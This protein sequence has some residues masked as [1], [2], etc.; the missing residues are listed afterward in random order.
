METINADVILPYP[1]RLTSTP[2]TG[3]PGGGDDDDGGTIE[4]PGGVIV[5]VPEAEEEAE[6]AFVETP[7]F[8]DCHSFGAAIG[9]SFS[10]NVVTL[11][12][13]YESRNQDWQ[14]ERL[15][16]DMSY[17]N[18]TQAQRNEIAAFHR[19]VRGQAMAFRVK[20]HSDFEVAQSEGR[21]TESATA[22]VYLM[23]KRY[24]YEVLTYDRDIH[25]PVAGTVKIYDGGVEMVSGF[26]VDYTTGEVTITSGTGP[27]TW[28]GEFDVPS[29]F[30]NDALQWTIVD[31]SGASLLYTSEQL[32]LIEVRL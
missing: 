21:L 9:P 11:K 6:L 15:V 28:S 29:R 18:R 27:F 12:S 22:G 7:R 17:I 25:K 1:S 31:R 26:T 2:P 19:Y 23:Q 20:D 16:F 8:P 3:S 5:P 32:Q 24:S 4:Y 30:M 13:G 10:T 14:C